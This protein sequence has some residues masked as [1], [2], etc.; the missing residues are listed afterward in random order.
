MIKRIYHHYEKWEDYKNGMW[1]KAEKKDE[2]RLLKLAIEFT[3]NHKKY[4]RAM[5]DV[6]REWKFT[7]EHNLTD[8]SINKKAFIGHCAVSYRL[9]IPEY[10]TR[11]AWH[12][13]TE[14]QQ[15]LAN[16]QAERA[17]KKWELNHKS[18]LQCQ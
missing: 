11:L 18:K 5:Q 3:G 13:L 15:N 9:N 4:G 17:I 16:A 7:C 10:I 12:E 6:I 1:N 14:E 2:G 8:N